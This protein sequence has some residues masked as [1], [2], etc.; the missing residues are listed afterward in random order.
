MGETG[1]SWGGTRRSLAVVQAAA[2]AHLHVHIPLSC[3]SFNAQPITLWSL[4]NPG[5]SVNLPQEEA[6]PRPA[7]DINGTNHPPDAQRAQAAADAEAV[8]GAAEAVAARDLK[9]VVLS[10]AEAGGIVEGGPAWMLSI[11]ELDRP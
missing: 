8:A 9:G 4:F 3:P 6:G 7:A 10:L 11:Q 5:I 2:H 1:S